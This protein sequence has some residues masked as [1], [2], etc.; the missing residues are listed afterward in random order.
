MA[1]RGALLLVAVDTFLH[2]VDVDERHHVLAGQQR[3]AAGQVRQQLPAHLLRL[4]GVPPGERAKERPQRGRC[5]DPAKQRRHRPVPQQVH[6]VD[7]VRSADHAGDQARHFQVRVHPAPAGDGHMLAGQRG[8][9]GPLR[10][11]HHRD[12][13]RP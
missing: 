7:A 13:A 9:A 3:R 1:E 4:P 10:Q 11:G 8:K 2:R 6:V 5:P 12:Q